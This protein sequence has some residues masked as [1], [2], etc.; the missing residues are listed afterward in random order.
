MAQA[1]P[2][3]MMGETAAELADL[4]K[5]YSELSKRAE[6]V[7]KQLSS[8]RAVMQRALGR[9]QPDKS[10]SPSKDEWPSYDELVSLHHDLPKVKGEIDR[11]EKQFKEWG[12]L[13]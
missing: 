13:G 10:S 5:K 1:D 11:L 2:Q 4:R 6:T 8:A 3:K 12:V 7:L 9:P